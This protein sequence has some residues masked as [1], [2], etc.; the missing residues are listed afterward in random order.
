M[1]RRELKEKFLRELTPS[2]RVYFLKKAREAVRLKGYMPGEDMFWYCFYVTLGERLR[3]I[4]SQGNGYV[5]F[6]FVQGVKDIEE[7]IREYEERLEK[8]KQ[9]SQYPEGEKFIEYF[10]E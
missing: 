5:K 4:G 3:Q 8:R 2:E 7:M 10:S 1:L 9:P 6:L